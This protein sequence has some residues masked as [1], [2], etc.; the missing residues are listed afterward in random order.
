MITAWHAVTAWLGAHPLAGLVLAAATVGGA[1]GLHVWRLRRRERH[2]AQLVEERTRLWQDEAAA[3]ARLR[4][5]ADPPPAEDDATSEAPVTRVLVVGE[6]RDRHE[7]MRAALDDLGITPVFA[8]SHWAATVAARQ[9][10]AEGSPYDLILVE[11]SLG[12]TGAGIHQ[13]RVPVAAL[14]PASEAHEA[15]L[16]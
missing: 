11:A 6:R 13:H 5:Q 2:L 14:P 9:A 15:G 16:G 10:D 3:N 12:N 1:T 4:A 7:A 8:D